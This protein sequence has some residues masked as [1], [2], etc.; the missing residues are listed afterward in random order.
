M[1]DYVLKVVYRFVAADD[2]EARGIARAASL[3]LPQIAGSE[4][5][6]VLRVHGLPQRGNLLPGGDDRRACSACSVVGSIPAERLRQRL[7]GEEA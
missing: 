3:D 5:E 2:A 1:G 7:G 4:V 6:T